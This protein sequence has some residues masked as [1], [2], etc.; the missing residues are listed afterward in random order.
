MKGRIGIFFK[1]N[2]KK[3]SIFLFLSLLLTSCSKEKRS[4]NAAEKMQEFVINISNYTHQYDS[5]FIIIPQNGEALGFNQADPD[6]ALNTNYLAAIDGIG[7]EEIFYNGAFAPDDYRIEML[8]Q[9]NAS[10]KILVSEY[11]NDNANITDALSRNYSQG[12]ISFVRN[13]ENYDYIQIPAN[14]PFENATNITSLSLAQNYLYLIGTSQYSSKQ[15]LIDA[16]AETNYDLVIIDLFFD[17]V[18]FTAAEINQLKLKKNGG[19]RLVISYVSIGSAEK[20]RYY[21]KKGWGHHHPLWLKKKYEGYPDEFWVKFWKKDWQDII[22][23]NDGSY[24]KKIL[25]SGFDGCYLDNVEA[26]YFLYYTD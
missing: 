15:E 25:D 7:V 13:N 10:E 4:E 3:L 23:G 26:Y 14:V 16:V 6:L 11:V 24:L 9:L 12:F 2:S 21:Y 8:Q 18:V 20:Y 19:Q 22:Y 5:D 1:N 17:D